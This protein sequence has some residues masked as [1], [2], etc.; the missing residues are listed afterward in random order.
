MTR[1]GR[2]QN[3][4]TLPIGTKRNGFVALV[5]AGPGDPELI[6]LKGVKHLARADVVLIDALASPELL[7]HCPHGVRVVQVGK[8]KFV[9]ATLV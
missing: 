1:P 3:E 4:R 7:D 8:R 9:K 2:T 5:G 6:T